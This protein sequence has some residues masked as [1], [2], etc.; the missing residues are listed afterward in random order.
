[1]SD[2]FYRTPMGKKFYEHDIPQLIHQIERLAN[3][4]EDRKKQW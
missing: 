3:I 1:M 2:D 4:L